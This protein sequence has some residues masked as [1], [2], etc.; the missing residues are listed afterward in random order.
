MREITLTKGY[1]AL[2]DDTD[3]DLASQYSWSA[4]IRRNTVYAQAYAGGGRAGF[5]KV[6]LHRLLMDAPPG[7]QVD[8]RDGNG[9][10]CQR[11]NM[12]LCTDAQNKANG[13]KRSKYP[14]KGIRPNKNKWQA[15]ISRPG[16]KYLGLFATPEEAAHAYDQAALETYGEFA[17]LNFPEA[18]Q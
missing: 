8:H 2:V 3:F 15:E 16:K 4:D 17:R 12:R 1:V 11:H 6:T 7:Q 9:L 10:N 13:P 18:T 14:Y 5:K